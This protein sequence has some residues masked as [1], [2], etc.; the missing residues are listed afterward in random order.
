MHNNYAA[1]KQIPDFPSILHESYLAEVQ[2][3][4]VQ[5]EKQK[6]ARAPLIKCH[7]RE[8]TVSQHAAFDCV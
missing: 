2:N 7:L 5:E 6:M 3:A 1:L 4:L 8:F